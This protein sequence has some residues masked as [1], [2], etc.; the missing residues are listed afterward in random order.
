MQ[1][2]RDVG[3]NGNRL[4]GRY[5]TRRHT[6]RAAQQA[7]TETDDDG[8]PASTI[9]CNLLALLTA[10]FAYLETV[11]LS[12]RGQCGNGV[13][14]QITLIKYA[15]RTAGDGGIDRADYVR[16][17]RSSPFQVDGI[18]RRSDRTL[19]FAGVY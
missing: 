12:D 3:R 7:G 4:H 5:V 13:R 9:D 18:R 6:G 17:K 16:I 14:I 8:E 11:P 10:I 2:G 1:I 19:W 15:R